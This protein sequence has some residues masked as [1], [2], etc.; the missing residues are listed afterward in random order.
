MA[1]DEDST[2]GLAGAD[3][4]TTRDTANT[5]VAVPPRASADIKAAFAASP[6]PTAITRAADGVIVFANVACL[7]MLGWEAADFVGQTM[8]DVGFWANAE[9]RTAM[10]EELAREG[11][12]SD[13]EEEIA[14]R[15]GE[16]KTVLVSISCFDLDGEAC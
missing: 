14:T 16:Q 7:Q 12:V 8:I 10:L 1:A 3:A 15:D 9:R 4:A 13:L 2:P 11:I 5:G 6:V